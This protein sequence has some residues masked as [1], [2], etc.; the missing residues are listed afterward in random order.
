MKEY[1]LLSLK[2][3]KDSH[4]VWWGPN[5]NGY[6]H[7]LNKAGVYTEETI[8]SNLPYYSNTSTM[9]VPV[10]LARKGHL[11]TVAVADSDNYRLFGIA[12]H[13]KTAKEY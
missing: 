13:L 3:S 8:N 4:F 2:W 6:T 5:N 12:E 10:E 11:Q 9:P 7:D 1:Y